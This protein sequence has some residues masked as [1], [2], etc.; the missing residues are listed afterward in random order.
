[1][2]ENDTL[3]AEKAAVKVRCEFMQKMQELCESYGVTVK[4]EIDFGGYSDAMFDD[5]YCRKYEICMYSGSEFS[6]F[7]NRTTDKD[8][9]EIVSRKNHV[10]KVSYSD[11][12]ECTWKIVKKHLE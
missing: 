10:C 9:E 12:G 4:G 5:Y 6:H 3:K 11:N 8:G 2:A 1:M 7:V